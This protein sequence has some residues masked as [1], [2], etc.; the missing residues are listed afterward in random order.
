MVVMSENKEKILLFLG[1]HETAS[2]GMWVYG[3]SLLDALLKNW[4][5]LGTDLDLHISYGVSDEM[6]AELE[7]IIKRSGSTLSAKNS[8]HK[9]GSLFR[10]RRLS[11]LSDLFQPSHGASLVHGTS[12]MLPL[13]PGVR[14]ILS[15][16]DLLQ[17]YAPGKAESL[18]VLLRRLFYRLLVRA[19]Y[20]LADVVLT[21]HKSTK[22]ELARRFGSSEKVKVLF[23]ALSSV[24]LNSDLPSDYQEHGVYLAFASRDPRKNIDLLIKEFAAWSSRGNRKLKLLLSSKNLRE[25]YSALASEAGIASAID[26]ICDVPEAEMVEL[27]RSCD[28][29]LFPSLA[30]G[31]GYPVYEAISQGTPV[32]C[33]LGTEIEELRAKLEPLIIECDCSEAGGLAC[34]LAKLDEFKPD[35]LVRR[36]ASNAV[37]ALL[38]PQK[39]GQDMLQIYHEILQK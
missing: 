17:A 35:S 25:Y 19:Q 8:L 9:I 13:A 12:N 23:P 28:A 33:N 10:L 24:F 18:Y 5:E 31:V 4:L 20:S 37:K 27:Y 7:D 26:F 14:K 1:R 11:L 34:G 16:H 30:E 32:L 36:A 15:L 21:D 29:L 39:F 2:S 22:D 3:K 6:E 38:N